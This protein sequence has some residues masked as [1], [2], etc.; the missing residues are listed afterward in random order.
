MNGDIR[1][2]RVIRTWLELE[3]PP[4][5]P[6]G[7]FQKI[8]SATHQ[9]RPQPRWVARLEGHH[10]DVIEGGRSSAPRLGLVL[11]VV[12]L[13]L[14]AAVAIFAIGSRPSNPVV[15]APSATATAALSGTATGAPGASTTTA[16]TPLPDEML[17][18]WYTS[19]PQFLWFIRAGDPACTAI[20]R[21][22]LDC[23]VVQP[24]TG[25][26]SAGAASIQAGQV[27]IDWVSGYCNA[28]IGRYAYSLNGDSLVLTEQ[29][30]GCQGGNLMLSRAG[31]GTTPTAPPPPTP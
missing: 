5:A 25:A 30:D 13:I 27:T 15:V 22:E 28:V 9:Q 16:V 10:M 19:G 4:S 26:D 1:A 11:A 17:G 12:G 7:L 3:A 29:P 18:A 2:D 23:L 31:T 20:A 14:V 21:T 6:D 8:D 24:G